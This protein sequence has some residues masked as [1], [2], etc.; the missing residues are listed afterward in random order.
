MMILCP[1]RER[2]QAAEVRWK[3]C[4]MMTEIEVVVNPS[5]HTHVYIRLHASVR[6][7]EV[8]P[9]EAPFRE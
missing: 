7:A 3:A 6:R 9:P 1:E 5:L 4:E 2:R 8:L